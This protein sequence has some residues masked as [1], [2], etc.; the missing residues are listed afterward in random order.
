MSIQRSV[1]IGLFF[2]VA[3]SVLGYY[4][5]FLTNSYITSRSH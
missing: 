5:L 1:L 3:L 4:T 2:L